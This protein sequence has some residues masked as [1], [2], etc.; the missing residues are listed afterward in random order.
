MHQQC[1]AMLGTC[2]LSAA[3]LL[4]L[5]RTFSYSWA[6]NARWLCRRGPSFPRDHRRATG[7]KH[8]LLAA[9][10]RS[11]SDT[12]N[13]LS[14]LLFLQWHVIVSALRA[15]LNPARCLASPFTRVLALRKLQ[16][17]VDPTEACCS[18]QHPAWRPN[19]PGGKGGSLMI[20]FRTPAFR[21]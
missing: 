15:Y 21:Q 9:E 4:Q 14:G 12:V 5:H 19:A 11:S 18:D 1:E 20:K 6:H 10:P 13:G 2:W 3:E 17:F 16:G 8:Q 7:H